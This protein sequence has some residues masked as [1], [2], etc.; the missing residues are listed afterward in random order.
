MA[1][2]FMN[3]LSSIMNALHTPTALKVGW[4]P[5]LNG[6]VGKATQLRVHRFWWRPLASSTLISS[7]A[8]INRLSRR[9]LQLLASPGSHGAPCGDL[10]RCHCGSFRHGAGPP[11][12]QQSQGWHCRSDELRWWGFHLHSPAAHVFTSASKLKD[13]VYTHG[14]WHVL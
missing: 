13:I 7:G 12:H 6:H 5:C 10:P 3:G 11:L 8:Q 14:V 2:R 9:T 4:C 1:M